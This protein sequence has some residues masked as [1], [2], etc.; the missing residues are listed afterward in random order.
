MEVDKSENLVPY[1]AWTTA[2]QLSYKKAVVRKKS[3]GKCL[4]ALYSARRQLRLLDENHSRRGSGKV[5][6][7]F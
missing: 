2:R 4:K 3:V 6:E 7:T 5:C 1:V